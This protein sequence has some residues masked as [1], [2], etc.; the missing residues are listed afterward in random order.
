MSA[1]HG[2]DSTA[3][4]GLDEELDVGVHEGRGHGH[5]GSVRKDELGVLTEA[6]DGVEDVIPSTTVQ[7]RA[8]VTELVDNLVEALVVS[9]FEL[10]S[11]LSPH[12]SQ[13]LQEWSQ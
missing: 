1:Y 10:S 6:L 13:T 3:M 7:P 5:S 4:A 12:P 9:I 2:V 11:S 8:V